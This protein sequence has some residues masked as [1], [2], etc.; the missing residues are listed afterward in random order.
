[1]E[2]ATSCTCYFH[3]IKAVK[4]CHRGLSLC[5]LERGS[6]KTDFTIQLGPLFICGRRLRPEC[7]P[8]VLGSGRRF[9]STR[10]RL[11]AASKS[12]VFVFRRYRFLSNYLRTRGTISLA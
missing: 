11:A 8:E 12:G 3:C 10:K 6:L 7:H 5:L 1:M 2:N 9:A 4:K